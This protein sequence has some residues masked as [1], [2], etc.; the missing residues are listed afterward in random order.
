MGMV[1]LKVILNRDSL[2]YRSLYGLDDID[3]IYRGT[4]RRPGFCYG[5]DVFV[6][7]GMTDDSY[8]MQKSEE[9]SPRAF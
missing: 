3:T 9:L 4:L 6:E 8:V 1:I 7:L 5:W 2:S